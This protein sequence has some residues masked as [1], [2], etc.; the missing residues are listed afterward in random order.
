MNRRLQTLKYLLSDYFAAVFAWFLFY[1]FRKVFIESANYGYHI[2]IEFNLYFF[3]SLIVIPLFWL[4]LHYVSGSY[5]KIY[6]KSRLQELGQTFNITLLGVILIFFTI[7]LDDTVFNYRN[8]Y[9]S[10]W[11]LFVL[12]FF[13]TYIPRLIITSSTIKKIKKGKVGFNTL[14][15][16]SNG[17]ALNLYNEITTQDEK[18]GYLFK[19]FINIYNKKDDSL[20]EYI[21]HL[22]SL[23]NL[24][25]IIREHDIEEVILAVESSE[26]KEIKK[27][28][29]ELQKVDVIT[30]VIP[31]IY[32]VMVGKVRMSSFLGTPLIIISHNLIPAWLENVKRLIDVFASIFAFIFLSPLYIFAAIGVKS[33]SNGPIFYK[34]ERIGIN[35]MPFYIYKFRSM[36]IGSE[37]KGPQLSSDNDSRI[38]KFGLLMRKTRLDEIPQ[39]YNVLKGDMSL[40]GPR[41]ERQFYINQI[42]EKAPHYLNLL[43]VK[44][45]ITSWGQVKYGYAENVEEM[46]ERLNYDIFYIENMSLY[47]DFKILIHTVL[48]I[49]RR[50]GK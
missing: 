20:C 28:V 36:F 34:Q 22:G 39:F 16:G 18:Y 26:H 50:D 37:K 21:P 12:Q 45:G 1:N 25:D 49:L 19:G 3:A 48:V 23:N 40:V 15:I 6:R 10:F 29:L 41:P 4:M 5:R 27:I 11:V 47:L 14:L 38:T 46:V 44:P 32:D 35:G 8:Y 17:Q 13:A 30:K 31:A 43:K 7:I 33:S 42:M 2:S 24:T 9:F